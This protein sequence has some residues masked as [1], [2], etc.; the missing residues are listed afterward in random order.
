MLRT[1]PLLFFIIKAAI[2]YFVLAAPFSFYDEMYGKLYRKCAVG[3]FYNFH[4][5]G[6]V[7]FAEGNEKSITRINVGNYDQVRSDGTG[8]TTFGYLNIRFLAYL[9]T[10]LLI[11]LILASPVNW[12]RK[13]QSL[14]IGLFLLTAFIMLLQWLHIMYLS[15]RAPWLNLIDYSETKKN[16]FNLAYKYLVEM[17]GFSRFLVVLIWLLVTFRIDD[18]KI[19]KP[20]STSIK[21]LKA[22]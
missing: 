8:K 1:K 11:S 20:K 18:L 22:H 4:G 6:F 15:I 10:A 2:I 19:L 3:L 21:P 5:N 16:N 9:P 7:R 17:P 13:L 14:L 12:K